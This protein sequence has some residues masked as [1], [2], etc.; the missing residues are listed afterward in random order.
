MQLDYDQ[1]IRL[2][3]DLER[4]RKEIPDGQSPREFAVDHMLQELSAEVDEMKSA[5]WSGDEE[6]LLGE[7]QDVYRTIRLIHL[8]LVRQDGPSFDSLTERAEA[9]QIRRGRT[10]MSEV[11]Y[12]GACA[13]ALS[14]AASPKGR[15]V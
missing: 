2:V 3:H 14:R 13:I 12:L 15:T 6:A 10:P 4:L 1:L 9:K 7:I 11:D 5:W 8:I